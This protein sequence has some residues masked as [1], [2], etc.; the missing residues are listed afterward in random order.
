MVTKQRDVAMVKVK[1]DTWARLNAGR[2]APGQSL[3]D[4]I[5]RLLDQAERET[6]EDASAS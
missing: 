2:T 4:V 1:T 5:R 3:D 6:R